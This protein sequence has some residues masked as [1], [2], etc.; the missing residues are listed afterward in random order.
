[1]VEGHGARDELEELVY[2]EKPGGAA[3]V[4]GS[5]EVTSLVTGT[6][7]GLSRWDCW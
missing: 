1:M 4:G 5:T 2:L 7:V 3:Q 6:T